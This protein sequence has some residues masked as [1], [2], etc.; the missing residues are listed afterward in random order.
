MT[1]HD[2]PTL[3]AALNATAGV[4]L[5]IGFYFVKQGRLT[6]HRNCMVA[7]FSCSV[8]FLVCYLYYHSQTGSTRFPG[9]G[10]A[11]TFYLGVLLTHTVLAALVPFLAVITLG[12]RIT[13]TH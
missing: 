9:T 12:V 13:P 3:N 11:R 8:L 10:A 1:I 6:A 7:A 4:L 2:F 5:L